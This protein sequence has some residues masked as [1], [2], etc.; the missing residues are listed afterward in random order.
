[1]TAP[2]E[3]IAV[4]TD[5]ATS[6]D[7]PSPG[8]EPR[9]SAQP[10]PEA[11]PSAEAA[12]GAMLGTQAPHEAVLAG[13]RSREPRSVSPNAIIAL[14]GT[15]LVT[16]LGAMTGLMTWQ[17]SSLGDGIDKLDAKIDTIYDKLD[18]KIDTKTGELRA[19]MQAGFREVNATLLDHTDR[20]ARLETAVGLL[21]PADDE[22]L[23]DAADPGPLDPPSTANSRTSGPEAEKRPS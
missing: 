19:E 5:Q 4:M 1:M 20:L 2:D 7:T 10:P 8:V 15:L 18:T 9:P 16:S 14:L 17:M 22:T 3:S 23:D 12:P 11:P 6:D 21:R 13:A